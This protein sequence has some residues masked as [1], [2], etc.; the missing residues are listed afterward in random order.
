MCISQEMCRDPADVV[1]MADALS[2][3][4]VSPN[5]LI[6]CC[7][8]SMRSCDPL[9]KLQTIDGVQAHR[10]RTHQ[11]DNPALASGCQGGRAYWPTNPGVSPAAPVASV[12]CMPQLMTATRCPVESPACWVLGTA[13]GGT[14]LVW[15]LGCG[16]GCRCGPTP[17]YVRVVCCDCDGKLGFIPGWPV[18]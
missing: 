7:A 1:A 13:Y 12:Q 9:Q 5:Y 11:L 15:A 2:H 8:I 16:G 14:C 10:I 3:T 17:G 6:G 4:V 18:T